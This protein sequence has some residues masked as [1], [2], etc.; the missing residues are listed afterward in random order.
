MVKIAFTIYM[1]I[2]LQT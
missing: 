1:V 2:D